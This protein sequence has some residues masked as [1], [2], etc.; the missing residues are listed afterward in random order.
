MSL[1]VGSRG[2]EHALAHGN[3][4]VAA[5]SLNGVA[6]LWPTRCRSVNTSTIH[7][8]TTSPHPIGKPISAWRQATQILDHSRHYTSTLLHHHFHHPS[9]HQSNQSNRP[10]LSLS[11]FTH[12]PAMP[13]DICC[14]HPPHRSLSPN[15][16]PARPSHTPL[17]S[18]D[19]I[20]AVAALPNDHPHSLK[21]PVQDRR[22]PKDLIRSPSLLGKLR[23]QFVLRRRGSVRSL[24]AE[25]WDGDARVLTGEGVVGEA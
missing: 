18:L 23:G 1:D 5:A 13:T 9:I 15:L 22:P 21:L 7:H 3:A 16:E 19:G 8:L 14:L 20:F 4:R 10:P 12:P 11:P 25:V 24:R 2:L 6:M 17:L